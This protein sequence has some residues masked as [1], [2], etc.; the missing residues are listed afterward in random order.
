[1]GQ[2]D[3]IKDSQRQ[4]I[5]NRQ[6]QE[7]DDFNN[8]MADRET[9]RQRWFGYK[10]NASQ[11][12]SRKEREKH[13]LQQA[14]AL[15][16]AYAK[17]YHQTMHNLNEA[18]NAVYEAQVKAAEAVNE[19]QNSLDQTIEKASTTA[20]GTAVFRSADG[21]VYTIFLSRSSRGMIFQFSSKNRKATDLT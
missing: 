17:L 15:S 21:S 9:G 3:E 12:K 19:A 10:R 7:Q 5:V 13:S 18:E 8:S 2:D 14:L 11:N 6:A 20:D 16:A 4:T 1:M